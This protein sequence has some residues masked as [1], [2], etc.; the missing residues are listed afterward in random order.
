[1]L[2]EYDAAGREGKGALLRREA[3]YTAHISKWRKQRDRG[4]ADRSG[5]PPQKRKT[6]EV[7]T[8]PLE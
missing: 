1:V 4:D 2:A 7:A 5:A 3:I 6:A 8:Q